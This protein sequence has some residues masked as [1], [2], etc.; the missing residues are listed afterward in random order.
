MKFHLKK[1]EYFEARIYIGSR[2]KYNGPQFT[3]LELKES[4][5]LFQ[6]NNGQDSNPVRIT[7]TTFVW[8]KYEEDGWEIAI[9]DYP[10]V[11]KPHEKLREFSYNMAV[12][13]LERFEQNRIS[14]VFPDEI[15]MLEADDAE[16]KK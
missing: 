10:R 14:I 11:S 15:V 2:V 13:L 3:F 7:P 9:I 4:I 8:E 16:E 5:G 1:N 6:A 12:H